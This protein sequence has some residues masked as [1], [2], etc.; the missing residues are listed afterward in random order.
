MEHSCLYSFI[1]TF[2]TIQLAMAF[3]F[4]K[5]SYKLFSFSWHV[6]GYHIPTVTDHRWQVVMI[7]IKDA[8]VVVAAFKQ[9]G[10]LYMGSEMIQSAVQ[11]CF[12][13]VGCGMLRYNRE[14][15]MK[16]NV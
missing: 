2:K 8:V 5:P 15:W 9:F 1:C 4:L 11:I 13:Q 14:Q 16:K 3:E 10:V 12:L 6:Q 7:S